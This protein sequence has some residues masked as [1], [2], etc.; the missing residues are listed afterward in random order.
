MVMV[1]FFSEYGGR[2]EGGDKRVFN[3]LE[4]NLLKFI[5]QEGK[6]TVTIR[7]RDFL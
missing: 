7:E 3:N 1:F 2:K 4:R 5:K 6:K